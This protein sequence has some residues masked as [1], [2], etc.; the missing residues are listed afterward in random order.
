MSTIPPESELLLSMFGRLAKYSRDELEVIEYLMSKYE[1]GRNKHGPLHIDSDTRDFL[2]ED[3]EEQADS[4][5]Y[6]AIMVIKRER[7]EAAQIGAND[8]A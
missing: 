5:F 1:A 6:R 4:R 8:A 3:T 7:R 2:E